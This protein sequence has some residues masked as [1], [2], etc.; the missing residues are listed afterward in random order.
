MRESVLRRDIERTYALVTG[1]KALRLF[2]C[3]R[4]PGVHAVIVFRFGQWL[5]RRNKVL[6]L[7]MEPVYQV[8]NVLIQVM[9]GIE[10]P[11]R[12][13]IGAGLLI[14]HFGGIA[15]SPDAVIGTNC[16]L[17]Q[18]VTIGISGQGE[19]SGAPV[20][21][22]DVYIAPGAKLFGKISIGNN[23]KVGANAVIHKDLPDNAIAVLDPGFT[24]VSHKGNRTTREA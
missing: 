16:N 12:A 11:R 23:V 13:S 9:W 15:V 24:I 1:S 10:L 14:S 19:R 18:G 22:N 20:I 7:L 2:R 17:S 4:S 5:L 3:L 21:G 8:L 6:R